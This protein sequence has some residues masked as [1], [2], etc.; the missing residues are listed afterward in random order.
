MLRPQD[1]IDLMLTLSNNKKAMT[2]PLIENVEIMAT[3]RSVEK[4]YGDTKSRA[5]N[6]ITLAVSAHNAARIIHARKVGRINVLLRAP[7][8]RS[9]GI[10][11]P[12]TLNSLLGKPEIKGRRRVRRPAEII[13]GRVGQ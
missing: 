13:V 12:I 7:G 3:G 6:T 10:E 4:L 5:Y 1:K 2:F 9:P 11:R 8:D